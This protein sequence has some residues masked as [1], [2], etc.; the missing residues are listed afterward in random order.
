MTTFFFFNI[1]LFILIGLIT[2]QY[3]MKLTRSYENFT[4]YMFRLLRA[5]FLGLSILYLGFFVQNKSSRRESVISWNCCFCF[6]PSDD[7][8]KVII[9]EITF[10]EEPVN[11]MPFLELCILP[12]VDFFEKLDGENWVSELFNG[13]S[14]TWAC[15]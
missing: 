11:R 14:K 1:N 10:E 2:L 8:L 4:L 13:S 3:C 7:N 5:S 6:F 12:E 9:N 15:S